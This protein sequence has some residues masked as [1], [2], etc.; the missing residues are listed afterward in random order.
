MAEPGG[1]AAVRRRHPRRAQ[2]RA[3]P[4]RQNAAGILGA[5]RCA[6][7]HPGKTPQASS[8]RADARR[9]IFGALRARPREARVGTSRPMDAPCA[10]AHGCTDTGFARRCHGG[11]RRRGRCAARGSLGAP[12]QA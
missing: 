2:M 12:G 10:E 5:R 1:A 11:V 9:A 6:P 7:S 3:E 8:A 4:S